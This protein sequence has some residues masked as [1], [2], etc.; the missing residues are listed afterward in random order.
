[1]MPEPACAWAAIDEERRR[2]RSSRCRC[3]CS[4]SESARSRPSRQRHRRPHELSPEVGG[5][6]I[7]RPTSARRSAGSVLIAIITAT[8]LTGIQGN[9]A[10][11]PDLQQ[12]ADVE[13][14]LEEARVSGETT[15][16]IIAENQKARLRALRSAPA[17]IALVA[18]AALP[19]TGPIPT[20]QP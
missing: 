5:L 16:A 17:I 6:Q 19:F 2:S 13:S 20:R 9:P 1:M 14:A 3:C 12:D 11:P 7:P 10:V 18:A 8:V 15:A 4:A